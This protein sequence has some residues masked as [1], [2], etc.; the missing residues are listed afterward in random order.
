MYQI[1][2]LANTDFM[3]QFKS[4]ELI[5]SHL[6]PQPYH[7]CLQAM[8]AYTKKRSKN[9]PDQVWILEHHPVYTQGALSKKKDILKTLPHPLVNT[10]RGGQITYHGPG[11]II[12]YTLMRIHSYAELGPFINTIESTIITILKNL[13]ISAKSDSKSRGVYVNNKKIASIGLRVKKNNIYHGFSLNANM[14]LSPFEYIN[15]CGKRQEVT[16]IKHLANTT[17]GH[18]YQACIDEIENTWK[19]N[20]KIIKNIGLEQKNPQKEK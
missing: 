7:T 9:H 6:E 5:I 10:D 17:L 19:L 18:V 20:K 13:G 14:D 1:E 12:C 11:Q 15:P 3:K 2:Q 8:Q 16:Q 4:E